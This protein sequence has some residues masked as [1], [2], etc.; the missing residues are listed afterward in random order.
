[1]IDDLLLKLK[2]RRLVVILVPLIGGLF[3][4]GVL[5]VKPG[6]ARIAVIKTELGGLSKKETSFGNIA[7]SE[8]RL[9]GYKQKLSGTGDKA[10][11]IEE[12]NSIADKAKFSILSITPDEKKSAGGGYLE[13]ISVRIEAE[14]NYHQLGEFISR[15]ENL[16]QYVKILTVDIDRNLSEGPVVAVSG[17]AAKPKASNYKIS[18]SV[19]LFNPTPGALWP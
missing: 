15:V 2:N 7:N 17:P 11:L 8:K 18:L 12:L 3:A 19:G 4:G 5:V 9:S 10:W 13:R 16:E 1:M 14:G 6:L